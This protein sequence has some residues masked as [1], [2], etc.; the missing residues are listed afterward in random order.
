MAK[1]RLII[2]TDIVIDALNGI[3][4]ARDLFKATEDIDIYCSIL[5][6]KELLSKNGLSDAERK[7]IISLLSCIKI[8]KIDDDIHAKF[9]VLL[10]KYGDNPRQFA[11]YIIAAS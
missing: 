11:Y 6:R 10:K 7:R 1:L 8:L 3:K 2:D 9:N 4:P 5:T